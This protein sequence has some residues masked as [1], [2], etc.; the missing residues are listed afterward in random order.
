[1]SNFQ[2]IPCQ[3]SWYVFE[4]SDTEPDA[5]ET[6]VL[7][8]VAAWMYDSGRTVPLAQKP[9][10]RGLSVI[11]GF[12]VHYD[13]SRSIIRK[14]YGNLKKLIGMDG[15]EESDGPVAFSHPL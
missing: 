13:S 14:R 6:I 9:D 2:V 15:E 5:E 1:M 11:N 10:A 12:C 7:R 8:R 3:G 4:V